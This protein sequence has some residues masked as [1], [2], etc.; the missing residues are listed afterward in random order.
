LAKST[1]SELEQ[2]VGADPYNAE[3]RHL[4]AAE[5]A[6]AGRYD[7]AKAEF[8]QAIALKP[9]AHIARFQLGLL[10]LTLGD[11][12]GATRI[13]QPLEALGEEAPLWHFKHGLEA[14]IRGELPLCRQK[15]TEGIARNSANPPLNEDMRLILAKV[16]GET[17]PV[18]TDFSLYGDTR[19]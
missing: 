12:I 15:L 17:A 2:A 10:L 8:L 18:R 13:W 19:H 9:D 16:A 11:S 3:L 5:Y 1:L 4:L 14:L 6:Q 7:S